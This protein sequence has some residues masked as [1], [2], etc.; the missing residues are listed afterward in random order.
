MRSFLVLCAKE[1]SVL[2]ESNVV[3]VLTGFTVNVMALLS[4][5]MKNSLRNQMM[6]HSTVYNVLFKSMQK[7]FLFHILTRQ[8]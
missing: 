8:K 2:K 5:N 3:T 1:V 7:S 6:Y 4:K